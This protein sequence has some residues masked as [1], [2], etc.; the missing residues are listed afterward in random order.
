[1]TSYASVL[2]GG[3][4]TLDTWFCTGKP[5]ADIVPTGFDSVEARYGIITASPITS[6]EVATQWAVGDV[7]PID[8]G[9]FYIVGAKISQVEL[10][11]TEVTISGR[12]L[13]AA[14]PNTY[15]YSAGIAETSAEGVIYLGTTYP[16]FTGLSCQPQYEISYITNTAPVTNQVGL[17]GTPGGAPSVAANPWSYLTTS[18]TKIAPNG[19]VLFDVQAERLPGAWL[20]FVTEKWQYVYDKMP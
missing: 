15:R 3:G 16:K 6:L 9:E 8:N 1:M 19:W 10:P 17:S 11:Y 7:F 18:F 4:L 2:F 12:G 20:W 13:S 14:K 5:Q